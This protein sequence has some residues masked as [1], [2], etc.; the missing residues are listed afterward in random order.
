MYR[1][2]GTDCTIREEDKIEVSSYNLLMAY[3]GYSI[4]HQN[5]EKPIQP[6]QGDDPRDSIP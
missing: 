6:L 4:E 1:C 2:D 3:Q 5:P